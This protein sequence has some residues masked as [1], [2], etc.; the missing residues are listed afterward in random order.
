MNNCRAC[1]IVEAK[2]RQPAAAPC[3]VS[4][5]RIDQK[6]ND[7]GID[8]VGL[9]IR[10]LCHGSG[11]DGCCRCAEHRLEDDVTPKRH[12]LRNHAVRGIVGASN[13]R[14]QASDNGSCASE[15]QA[16]AYQPV[17]G[18]SDA[19]V[20]HVL[21]QDVAGVLGPRQTGLT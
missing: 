8:T 16:E 14:I 9:E 2:G 20:H 7:G 18:R 5:D 19:E 10:P 3:P 1:K 11:N 15:H 13:Q 6:G 4:A 21:H 17:A 12:G